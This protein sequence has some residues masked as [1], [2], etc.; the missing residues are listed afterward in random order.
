MPVQVLSFPRSER[1]HTAE[2]IQIQCITLR[3]YTLG[4]NALIKMRAVVR[5]SS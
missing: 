1:P 4:F 3:L 2:M 5:T